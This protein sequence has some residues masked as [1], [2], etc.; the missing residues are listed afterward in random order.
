[1]LREFSYERISSLPEGIIQN[2][3]IVKALL[4]GWLLF[5]G[6]RIEPQGS[7]LDWSSST[8]I[9]LMHS[10]WVMVPQ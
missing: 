2:G 3:G 6:E 7:A 4:P 9:D 10:G 8:M 1:M 5:S